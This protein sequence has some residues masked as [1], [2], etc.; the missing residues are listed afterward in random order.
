MVKEATFQ[1]I[2]TK[3]VI[4]RKDITR[5]EN[6]WRKFSKRIMQLLTWVTSAFISSE[7]LI[8]ICFSYGTK[9]ND[10]KTFILISWPA[11]AEY[12]VFNQRLN[13]LNK[14]AEQKHSKK[15]KTTEI[16]IWLFDVKFRNFKK[17]P[18][19]AKFNISWGSEIAFKTG[20][21][22]ASES[23]S[24]KPLIIITKKIKNNC[25]FLLLVKKLINSKIFN[26]EPFKIKLIF[27]LQITI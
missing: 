17:F 2:R 21:N 25:N 9:I 20:N 26:I 23:P 10:L 6:T 22:E 1:L 27:L 11:I 5:L 24:D 8:N 7:E 13:V 12:L 16:I 15:I 18:T 14:E 19:I 3:M 4:K